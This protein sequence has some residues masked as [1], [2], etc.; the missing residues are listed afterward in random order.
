[1]SLTPGGMKE[2]RDNVL[3]LMEILW[4]PQNTLRVFHVTGSNGK[5]SVCQMISQILWKTFWK[6]VG[7]FTSPHFINITERFQINGKQISERKLNEYY[8]RV[9][10]LGEKHNIPLSFFEIQVVATILY[11]CDEKVDYAVVEVWLGGTYDGTNIFTHPLACFITSIALEHTHVLGKTK[12]SVLKNKLGIAKPHTK[13]YTPLRNKT[14]E[15]YCQKNHVQLRPIGETQEKNITNLPGEHQQRNA[16][17]VF[18]ALRD[19]WFNEAKIKE[20]LNHIENPGRF[21]WLSPTLLVDTANNEENVAILAQMLQKISQEKEIIA[22]FGTTQTDPAYAA[23]LAE[24]IPTKHRILVDEFCDRS[25]PCSEY[26][27]LLEHAE[28][29]HMGKI[30]KLPTLKGQKIYVVFWSFYLVGEIM[31]VSRYKPFALQ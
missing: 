1:M 25:L 21:H 16:A 14:L 17:L 4:N 22:L 31:R 10:H 24:M 12:I 3:Q 11:F 13:L 27:H 15:T 8:D 19:E 7:L 18:Q 30:K 2:W 26:S 5:W 29:W 23:R 20:G 28:V 9:V 6:K